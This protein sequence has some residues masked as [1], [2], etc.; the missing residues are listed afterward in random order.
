MRKLN[1]NPRLIDQNSEYDING[2]LSRIRINKWFCFHDWVY[3]R[4]GDAIRRHRICTKC[5]KRQK[6]AD[7]LNRSRRWI[8]G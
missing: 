5:Y 1:Y 4:F 2:L 8:N 7:L 6:N 3:W